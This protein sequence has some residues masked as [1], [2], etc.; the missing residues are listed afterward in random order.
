MFILPWRG[1]QPG[2]KGPLAVPAM[3]VADDPDKGF[4]R[5]ILGVRCRYQ[6]RLAKWVHPPIPELDIQLA[7]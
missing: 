3:K 1:H 6:T 2:L 5:R 4:L 7:R